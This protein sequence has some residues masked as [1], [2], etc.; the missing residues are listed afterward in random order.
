[1]AEEGWWAYNA[2]GWGGSYT[3][4]A[5]MLPPHV[6]TYVVVIRSTLQNVS[7]TCSGCQACACLVVHAGGCCMSVTI[8]TSPAYIEEL[9][10]H[11]QGRG[12]DTNQVPF[13]WI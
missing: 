1:M 10:S 2:F 8:A 13:N 7:E 12:R 9:G 4:T 3:R 6:S 5:G 11:E